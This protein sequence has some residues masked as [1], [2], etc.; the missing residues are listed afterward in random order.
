L[1]PDDPNQ[2]GVT[3]ITAVPGSLNLTNFLN[4]NNLYLS[5]TQEISLKP[6]LDIATVISTNRV[7]MKPT[8][9]YLD[10]NPFIEVPDTFSA[11]EIETSI[12]ASL[13]SIQDFYTNNL[14]GLGKSLKFAQLVSVLSNAPGVIS[15]DIDILYHFVLNYDSFYSSKT[16]VFNLPVLQLKDANGRII[17]D[18]NN[19]PKFT[20]FIKKR[21][22]VIDYQN[23]SRNVNDH[24]T[25]FTL[26]IELSPVYGKLT[27]SNSTREMYNID[28]SKVEF[29][30]FQLLGSGNTKELSSK[31]TEFKIT[32]G[33][34][35]VPSLYEVLSNNERVEWSINMNGLNVGKLIRDIATETFTVELTSANISDLTNTIGV[36]SATTGSTNLISLELVTETDQFGVANTFYSMSFLLEN[37]KFSDIRLNSKNKLAD[38]VFTPSNSYSWTFANEVTYGEDVVFSGASSIDTMTVTFGTANTTF[39]VVEHINGSFELRNSNHGYLTN[40]NQRNDLLLEENWTMVQ[41]T[42]AKT[43]EFSSIASTVNNLQVIKVND[44]KEINIQTIANTSSVLHNTYFSIFSAEDSTEYYVFFDDGSSTAI[45]PDRIDPNIE[46]VTVTLAV[47]AQPSAVASS[48]LTAFTN[49]TGNNVNAG[50]DFDLVVTND[51]VNIIWTANGKSTDPTDGPT[52]TNRNTS[53]AFGLTS[54][55]FESVRT[56]GYNLTTDLQDLTPG[57]YIKIEDTSGNLSAFNTGLFEIESIDYTLGEITIYNRRGITDSKGIGVITHWEVSAGVFGDHTLYTYDIY[58][59]VS[60]G[61]MNY[62]TGELV[63]KDTAKGYTDFANNEVINGSVK[64]IFN[65]YTNTNTNQ[66]DKIRITPIDNYSSSG[67]YLGVNNNF[68]GV[69]NQYIVTNIAQPQIK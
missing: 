59:D 19:N 32:D 11:A 5:D 7:F 51:I 33:T 14:S 48:I 34:N 69:F 26:P 9:L 68:D 57:Q 41:N 24:Y 31:S 42:N 52:V 45:E 36:R 22:D 18:N 10:I 12:N 65:E 13:T 29:I 44:F 47:D 15:A 62:E 66:M 46:L 43:Y 61:T 64:E 4:E 17:Y 50:A 37:T 39:L 60:L 58:H 35:Y 20:N 23:S 56:G 8:Y 67:T 38:I 40:Y 63:F 1:F 21:Q 3:Y 2:R 28:I 53:F 25:Q 6:T 49:H 30:T 27:S 54:N 55:F 16:T